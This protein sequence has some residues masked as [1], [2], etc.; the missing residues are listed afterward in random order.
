M[1][2]DLFPSA[3]FR[4]GLSVHV[5][6]L[7]RLQDSLAGPRKAASRA[8]SG[9]HAAQRDACERHACERHAAQ[10]HAQEWHAAEGRHAQGPGLQAGLWISAGRWVVGGTACV[11]A[12]PKESGARG[13]VGSQSEAR[14]EARDREAPEASERAARI[15]LL[16]LIPYQ[17]DSSSMF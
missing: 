7:D 16:T 14:E 10:R 4:I 3:H 11:E 13:G 8:E 12:D 1:C 6:V 9:G 5:S 17:H 15:E 2:R